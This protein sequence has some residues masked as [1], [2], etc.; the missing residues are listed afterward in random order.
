VRV[1]WIGF[2]HK[3]VPQTTL[4][5]KNSSSVAINSFRTH[6]FLVW[7]ANPRTS[8]D[9]IQ[10]EALQRGK[11]YTVGD[12]N[13]IVTIEPG[14]EFVRHDASQQT[15]EAAQHAIQVCDNR[16]ALA[17]AGAAVAGDT[18][19]PNEGE[20]GSDSAA[21]ATTAPPALES[22]C[23]AEALGHWFSER[24]QE[25][26]FEWTL[27]R[28]IKAG[29]NGYGCEGGSGGRLLSDGRPADVAAGAAGNEV[30]GNGDNVCLNLAPVVAEGDQELGLL[31][32]QG[33]RATERP[34]VSEIFLFYIS[35]AVSTYTL[36]AVLPSNFVG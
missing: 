28:N 18:G 13:D 12:T 16:H 23:V 10:A 33:D 22:E 27:Y 35:F 5:V 3:L 36:T 14:L 19:A 30:A 29:L 21:V 1:Y 20:A 34:P 25:L 24:R 15:L 11:A 6:R 4:P 17:A 9:Q 26:D 32:K 31:A 2:D 7:Y 8:E